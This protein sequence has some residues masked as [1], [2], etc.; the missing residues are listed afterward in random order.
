MVL[1]LWLSKGNPV[2]N[3]SVKRVEMDFMHG[4]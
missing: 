2:T 4:Q 1:W 3:P